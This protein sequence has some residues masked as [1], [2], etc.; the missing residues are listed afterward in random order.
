[1]QKTTVA[2]ISAILG[3]MLIAGC[4]NNQAPTHRWASAEAVDQV[5]YHNDHAQ[6][7]ARANMSDDKALDT[8]S[9][10]FKAYKQCM[11]NS[12]YEL[13]AYNSR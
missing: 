1:M 11:N 2:A 9:A 10:E 4:T 12:G 7:Q 8:A 13:T 5:K 3:A 6:C